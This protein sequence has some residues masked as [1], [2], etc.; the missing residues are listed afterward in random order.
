MKVLLFIS[1]LLLADLC[2]GKGALRGMFPDKHPP[3]RANGVD[4][5]EPVFLSPLIA[6]GQYDQGKVAGFHKRWY[7][8]LRQ[9]S[10]YSKLQL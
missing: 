3:M 9:E 10:T 1:L 5:G 4:P 2:L 8:P 7:S 6:K